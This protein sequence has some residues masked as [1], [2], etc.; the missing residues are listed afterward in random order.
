MNGIPPVDLTRTRSPPPPKSCGK[1]RWS[2]RSLEWVFRSEVVI[3][4]RMGILLNEWD[5]T[6]GLDADTL[7]ATAEKLRQGPMV[8]KI[9]GMGIH[10]GLTMETMLDPAV[11]PFLYDHR[12]D[13]TPVL[14][15]V[16]GIEG[17]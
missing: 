11:Q 7:A 5:S 12:I 16:M 8:G 4:Q 15:G 10:S 14:P 9:T 3:G 6:G 2:A 17:F 13:G 1:D